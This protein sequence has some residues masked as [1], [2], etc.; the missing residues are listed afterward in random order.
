MERRLRLL[1][2]PPEVISSARMGAY[3]TA[4]LLS[5]AKLQRLQLSTI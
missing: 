5:M 2:V 1:F 4:R 3:Y